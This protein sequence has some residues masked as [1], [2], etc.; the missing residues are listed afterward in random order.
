MYLRLGRKLFIKYKSMPEYVI[1]YVTSKCNA[2]CPYC[3]YWKELNKKEN[4]LSLEEVQKMAST[5]DPF[6]FLLIGG[7]EPFLRKEL[8]EI[9][10]IFYDTNHIPYCSIPTNGIATQLTIQAV[11]KIMTLCPDLNLIVSLSIEGFEETYDAMKQVPGGFKKAIETFHELKKLKTEF[12]TLNV[13]VNITYASY[14]Q[15]KMIDFYKWVRD[16][17]KPDLVSP[18]L[19]RGNP[20]ETAAKQGLSVEKYEQFTNMIE[21]DYYEKKLRG[22]DNFLNKR[23]AIASRFIRSKRIADTARTNAYHSRCYAGIINAVIYPEGDVFPCE[24][25]EDKK[26]G[27]IRD[28]GL[29]FRKLWFSKET[30]TITDWIKDTNCR[31]THE[32]FVTPSILF[33]PTYLPKLIKGASP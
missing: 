1:F 20:K 26:I 30:K 23:M 15:D 16:E 3:F 7:G 2:K 17:L 24:I 25:L 29:D 5:M 4:V 18:N 27:N 14:T 22:F 19:V 12:P 9:I 28:Y 13:G 8:P 33:N 6:L 10:K 32:C 21:H 31:C 11:R